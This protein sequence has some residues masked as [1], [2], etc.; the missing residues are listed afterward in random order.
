MLFFITRY[1][2]SNV[3]AA[4]FFQC[5]WKVPQPKLVPHLQHSF[6]L[7]DNCDLYVIQRHTTAM[8]A[9]C[10]WNQKADASKAISSL[11]TENIM[12]HSIYELTNNEFL[13]KNISCSSWTYSLKISLVFVFP[14]LLSAHIEA[15][16]SSN[17]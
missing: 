2:Y 12:M 16:T 4:I 7:A 3:F 8:Q 9:V 14:T 5:N 13:L 1:F 17:S 10:K 11:G 15:L 6:S